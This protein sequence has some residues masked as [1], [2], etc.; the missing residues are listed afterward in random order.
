MSTTLHREYKD[1]TPYGYIK[2]DKVYLKGYFDFEDREIGVVRESDEESLKYFVNRYSTVLDKIQAVKDSIAEAEN[3]GSYLMKLLHMRT[4]LAQYNGLGDFPALFLMIDELEDDIR[5]YIEKNRDKNYEIKKALL[6]EAEALRDDTQWKETAERFKELKQNW[7]KT[8]SAHK[9]VE[10]VLT[11]RF[12]KALAA[13][14][15]KRKTYYKELN[16]QNKDRTSKY[17]SLLNQVKRI[18]KIGGGADFVN[19]VK[20]IQKEWKDVGKIAQKVFLKLSNE[21]KRETSKFFNDLKMGTAS[22]YVQPSSSYYGSRQPVQPIRRK[23]SI[24]V[25]RELLQTVEDML[26]QDAPFNINTVK[27]VQESWKELGKLPQA[28]DKDLNLKFRIVCNEIFESHFLDRTARSLEVEYDSMSPFEQLKAKADLLKQ[29]LRQDEEE[30]DNFNEEYG[31]L[32][33]DINT[34]NMGPRESQLYQQRNNYVNKL[35]TKQRILKKIED[36]MMLI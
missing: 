8:G 3:K 12:N 32:L 15:E 16:R 14:F 20:D 29:S 35:K 31:N 4:Y 17:K 23:S 19:E 18:N 28:E 2:G 10:D 9:E 34:Q 22:E 25:K 33:V 26:K 5:G 13:F 27:K 21:F 30:L 7:I 11:E 1:I 6:A 36:K 24:E